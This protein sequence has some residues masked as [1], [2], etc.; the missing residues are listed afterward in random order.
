M[1]TDGKDTTYYGPEH[2]NTREFL[3]MIPAGVIILFIFGVFCELMCSRRS[4]T[5]SINTL[6]KVDV[7][8]PAS[9]ASAS[10]PKPKDNATAQTVITITEC[11]PS[12]S[13][14][15]EEAKTQACEVY[16]PSNFSVPQF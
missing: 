10:P 16:C 3:L 7:P 2:S 11:A 14:Q 13:K 5:K 12:T 4:L 6:N 15:Q 9:P 8:Q 1:D